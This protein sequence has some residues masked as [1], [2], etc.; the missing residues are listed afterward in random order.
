MDALMQRKLEFAARELT[1]ERFFA[2]EAKCPFEDARKQQPYDRLLLVLS[3]EKHEPMYLDGQYVEVKLTAG[4]AYLLEKNQW[5]FQS[6]EHRHELLCVVPRPACLRVAYYDIRPGE[7]PR[8]PDNLGASHHTGLPPSKA[9][10]STFSALRDREMSA[11]PHLRCLVR[12]ALLLALEECGREPVAGGKALATFN[13]VCLYVEKHF[14]EEI[15][16]EDVAERFELSP[17]Y[18]SQLF[19]QMSGHGFL[20]YLT[21]CRLNHARRLL[22]LTNQTVKEVCVNSGFGNEI[23]FIRR[24][25]ELTGVPP[26]QFRLQQRMRPPT[27]PSRN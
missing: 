20:E 17:G 8:H 5:E 14:T 2:P 3:G 19:R 9:L 18:L 11:G 7:S 4:D 13:R 22:S 24:F 1:L 10:L 16:R 25:R 27:P 15:T 6:W 26:G 12:A 21:E 23:Y